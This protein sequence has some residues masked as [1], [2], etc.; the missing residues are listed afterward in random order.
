MCSHPEKNQATNLPCMVRYCPFI[1]SDEIHCP[2]FN[3]HSHSCW[4][5]GWPLLP[6]LSSSARSTWSSSHQARQQLLAWAAVSRTPVVKDQRFA[7]HSP[8]IGVHPT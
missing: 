1:L 6:P 7:A 2:I 3:Q 4:G 8:D 5:A